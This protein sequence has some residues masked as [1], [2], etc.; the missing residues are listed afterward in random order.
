[1]T[2]IIDACGRSC[3]EP[4]IMTKKAVARG[5]SQFEVLVDNATA[6]GNVTR[7][8]ENAGFKVDE[9][10]KDGVFHLRLGK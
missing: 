9:A 3:P 1:M 7:F 8:A 10:R 5:G 2:K 6:A 4:V